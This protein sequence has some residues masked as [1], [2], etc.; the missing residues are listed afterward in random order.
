[1]SE[2]SSLTWGDVVS[3]VRTNSVLPSELPSSAT[4]TSKFSVIL[5]ITLRDSGIARSSAGRSLKTGIIAVISGAVIVFLLPNTAGNPVA[6]PDR[7]FHAPLRIVLIR[8]HPGDIDAVF[9]VCRYECAVTGGVDRSGPRVDR[10]P[11][12]MDLPLLKTK[13]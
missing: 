7:A 9:F 4:I 13:T 11:A 1:M 12:P 6:R 10:H 2:C 5:E 3:Y 8:K